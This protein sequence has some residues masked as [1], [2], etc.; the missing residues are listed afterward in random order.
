MLLELIKYTMT[1]FF[2][3]LA[4]SSFHHCAMNCMQGAPLYVTV[5]FLPFT[6]CSA[7]E[8]KTSI[9]FK[10]LTPPSTP[11]SPCSSTNTHAMHEQT[12]P[13]VHNSTLGQHSLHGQPAV[14]SSA[15]SQRTLPLHSQTPPFA[16]PC[17]PQSHNAHFNH[18]HRW[19]SILFRGVS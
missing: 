14:T 1:F 15:L 7:Y 16:V 10:P 12:S 13:L 9:G 5:C 17:P 11:V 8:R 6:L 4:L 3:S 18:E 19:E 2:S